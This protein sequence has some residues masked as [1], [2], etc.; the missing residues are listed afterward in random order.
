MCH[1]LEK[2]HHKKKFFIKSFVISLIVLAIVCLICSLGYNFMAGMAN[3]FYGIDFDDYA[4]VFVLVF[5]IWK[6][7]ILQFTLVPAIAMC[8]IEKHIKK[9]EKENL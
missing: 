9:E 5:G 4:E 8:M 6:I 1:H 7:L 3:K 2:L